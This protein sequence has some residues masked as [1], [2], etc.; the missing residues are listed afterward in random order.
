MLAFRRRVSD[1]RRDT[2]RER[3]HETTAQ[4]HRLAADRRRR[5][6]HRFRAGRR[7]RTAAGPAARAVTAGPGD[8]DTAHRAIGAACGSATVAHPRAAAHR[9][10]HHRDRSRRRADPAA[11]A[12]C[13]VADAR[14]ARARACGG[15]HDTERAVAG[16]PRPA[17]RRAAGARGNV[18]APRLAAA[19]RARS[20]GQLRLQPSVSRQ[21][22]RSLRGGN[23][24]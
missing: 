13:A 3:M 24:G 5:R 22:C 14:G 7:A 11:P 10:R 12:R 23:S 15:L 6:G 8:G 1:L 19:A 20:G 17:A 16:G 2:A 4:R 9:T 21:R 18:H